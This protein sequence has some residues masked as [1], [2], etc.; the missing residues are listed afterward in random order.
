M[1]RQRIEQIKKEKIAIPRKA[2]QIKPQWE[3]ERAEELNKRWQVRVSNKDALRTELRSKSRCGN[4]KHKIGK[5]LYRKEFLSLAVGLSQF[6]KLE[7]EAKE[8]FK[9]SGPKGTDLYMASSADYL[10]L[11]THYSTKIDSHRP[12]LSGWPAQQTVEL[13]F[14]SDWIFV[15]FSPP[16]FIHQNSQGFF[17]KGNHFSLIL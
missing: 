17:E 4:Y 2:V 6:I 14:R 7:K 3:K 10:A 11:L 16:S 9:D 13:A 1:N 5:E 12:D 8:V 15:Y